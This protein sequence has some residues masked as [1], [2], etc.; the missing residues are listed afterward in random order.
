[1]IT[2]KGKAKCIYSCYKSKLIF[3]SFRFDSKRVGFGSFHSEDVEQLIRLPESDYK[4]PSLLVNNSANTL[5]S[6]TV[7]SKF[8]KVARDLFKINFIDWNFIN[9]GAFGGV[10]EELSKE[11]ASWSAKCEENPLKFYDRDLLPCIAYVVRVVSK[12]F[13]CPSD[14]LVP[15]QNVTSGLNAII[16]S[17]VLDEG[18]QLLCLSLTYGSTKKILKAKA[19]SSKSKLIIV[20]IPFPILSSEDIIESIKSYLNNN[21]K[22]VVLDQITSNTAL[23]LPIIEIAKLCK[24]FGAIVIIDAAHVMMSNKVSI[25]PSESTRDSSLSTEQLTIS[26]VADFWLTNGHKWLS[27]PKGCAFLWVSPQMKNKLRPSIISHGYQPGG[28]DMKYCLPDRLLSSFIWDGCRDYSA[29]LCVPSAIKFWECYP[30]VGEDGCRHYMQTLLREATELLMNEW[31]L[32]EF[33]MIA[34]YHLR[35]KSPM[36]LIPLPVKVGTIRDTRLGM[37]DDYA[38]QL[39]EHLHHNH[40]IEVPIKCLEGRLFVRISSH[41]YNSI[42]QYQELSH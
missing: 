23:S 16:N 15:I 10:L 33:D 39:Q 3:R 29:I 31:K 32:D 17:L 26:E 34:P 42:D 12:Y 30:H 13:N 41:I 28:D 25:Y 9:H 38:F 7:P 22:A 11:Q 24:S 8:G 36:A 35:K 40:K 6:S 2:N 19:Q 5:L 21:V 20:D 4:P 18:D 37:T 1:M 27:A 14:E